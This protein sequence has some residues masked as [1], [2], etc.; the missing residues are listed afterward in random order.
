MGGVTRSVTQGFSSTMLMT[1]ALASDITTAI[2]AGFSFGSD[3]FGFDSSTSITASVSSSL[4]R[5]WRENYSE[6]ETRK[7]TC[8][9]YETGK[10]FKGGCM[11][12]LQMETEYLLLSGGKMTWSPGIIKCTPYAK[13]PM[14]PPFSS[15]SNE[16][17]DFC[18]YELVRKY[19]AHWQP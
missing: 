8:E 17:C 19:G 12:Q 7:Y 6:F 4:A 3:G 16:K 1:S 11:W 10:P 15:C 18:K 9:T 2:R 13:P 14:C 5:Y